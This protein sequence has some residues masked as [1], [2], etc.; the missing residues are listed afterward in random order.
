MTKLITHCGRHVPVVKRSI[1]LSSQVL[2]TVSLQ[3]T[4]ICYEA[5]VFW[6]LDKNP[7]KKAAIEYP[8]NVSPV[9][10]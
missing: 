8:F 5:G 9:Q 10:V 4:V 1:L 7:S 2:S 6:V 3:P